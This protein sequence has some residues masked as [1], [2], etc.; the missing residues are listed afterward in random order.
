M[1]FFSTLCLTK[2]LLFQPQRYSQFSQLLTMNMTTIRGVDLELRRM[3]VRR[4]LTEP[5]LR[6]LTLVSC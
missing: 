2:L 3:Y 6:S 4:M 5:G 1:N